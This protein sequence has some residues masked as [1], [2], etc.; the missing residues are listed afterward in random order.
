MDKNKD[1]WT[2]VERKVLNFLFAHPTTSFHG[3]EL[4]RQI[5]VSPTSITNAVKR[6]ANKNLVTST[7]DILLSVKLNRENPK[8]FES[9]RWANLSNLYESGLVDLISKK[10]PGS[11]II[12]FGSYSLGED[13]EESDIDIALIGGS[14]PFNLE[15]ELFKFESNQLLKRKINVEYINKFKDL[16]AT[17]Q[18]S[19]INGIVLKGA[20]QL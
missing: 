20:L 12:V 18:E 15:P 11:A 2:E 17:L 19:I 1:K 14:K 4:A 8:S 9:K 13:T 16:K 6:L 10:A 3:R 5:K 7:K